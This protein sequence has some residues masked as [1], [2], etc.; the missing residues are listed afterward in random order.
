[1]YKLSQ[2]VIV[3]ARR[4]PTT[5]ANALS[6]A[7]G[8]SQT[9]GEGGT[10]RVSSRAFQRPFR[11]CNPLQLPHGT[12][13]HPQGGRTLLRPS[14]RALASGTNALRSCCLAAWCN[15]IIWSYESAVA[16]EADLD[17]YPC[18]FMASGTS[19]SS[20]TQGDLLCF[21][22]LASPGR[23]SASLANLESLLPIWSNKWA[24]RPP[25]VTQVQSHAGTLFEGSFK[26]PLSLA[27]I[28]SDQI[29]P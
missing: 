17:R 28:C 6:E 14:L 9:R 22:G 13:E 1:M 20:R 12:L 8:P 24:A 29:L 11:C 16:G 25:Q 10:R 2:Q 19:A 21:M 7:Q 26:L 5:P 4:N 27:L 18:C 15:S 3:A 23:R